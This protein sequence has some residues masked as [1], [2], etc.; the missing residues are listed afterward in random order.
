MTA[1]PVAVEKPGTKAVI[2]I[3]GRRHNRYMSLALALQCVSIIDRGIDLS[4]WRGVLDFWRRMTKRMEE[5]TAV[6]K[7]TLTWSVV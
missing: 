1:L 3:K 2:G 5:F 6:P 4:N 7:R